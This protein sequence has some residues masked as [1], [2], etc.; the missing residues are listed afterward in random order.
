MGKLFACGA[1]VSDTA[2]GGKE[3]VIQGDVLDPLAAMLEDKFQV[4]EGRGTKEEWRNGGR[5]ACVCSGGRVKGR[6]CRMRRRAL[7]AVLACRAGVPI[8]DSIHPKCAC[9]QV[10]A[11][12]IVLKP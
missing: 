8:S 5:A 2:S 12:N 10:P 7:A 11:E 6:A 1:S 9:T 4:R 3:I